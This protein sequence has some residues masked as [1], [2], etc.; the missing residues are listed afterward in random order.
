MRRSIT[1]P[2]ALLVAMAMGLTL[3]PVAGAEDDS[4]SSA[5]HD[6][7]YATVHAGRWGPI[8]FGDTL[9]QARDRGAVLRRARGTKE[10]FEEFGCGFWNV[11]DAHG[12][13]AGA[14]M[15]WDVDGKRVIKRAD[16]YQ[17]IHPPITTG[18]KVFFGMTEKRLL[19]RAARHDWNIRVRQHPF[20]GPR[21]H[22]ILHIVRRANGRTLTFKY[23]TVR[24]EGRTRVVEIYAGH[25]NAV[26][27]IEGCA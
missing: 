15:V 27:L 12:R 18:S 11:L 25:R 5:G 23:L 1:L 20:G 7:T 22:E 10:F 19:R 2:L 8:R 16:F 9:K 14:V 6:D 26:R 3:V 13:R 24:E 4:R 17:A 21:D